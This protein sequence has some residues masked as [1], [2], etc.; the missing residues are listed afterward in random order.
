VPFASWEKSTEQRSR[1]RIVN[2]AIILIQ[3]LSSSLNVDTSRFL[4]SM[5]RNRKH[6]PKCRS[7]SSK[8]KFL[9]VSTLKFSPVSYAILQSLF[10]LPSRITLHSLLN[11]VQCRMGINVHVFIMLKDSV[12]TM[13]DKVSV[14]CLMFDEISFRRLTVLE[15]LRTLEAMAWQTILHI[16]Y[17]S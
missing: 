4:S 10:P 12:Q 17:W 2:W 13:S 8:E 1:G 3:S 5:F 14:R 9:T 16:F 7:W 6:Q 11:T 15:A